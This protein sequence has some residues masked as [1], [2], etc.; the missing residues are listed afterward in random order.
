MSLANAAYTMAKLY[1]KLKLEFGPMNTSLARKTCHRLVLGATLLTTSHLHA[2]EPRPVTTASLDML[3]VSA[4]RDAPAEVV[5]LNRAMLSAELNARIVAVRAE[6]GDRVA[7]GDVL[8]ELD[9]RDYIAR[10]EQAAATLA[11]LEAQIDFA[12]YRSKRART[13]SERNAVAEEALRER[14]TTL[15]R[16]VAERDGQRAA[17]GTARLQVERCMVRAP[18]SAA[19][20]A[21]P[22]QLG[23]LAAPGTPLVELLDVES[24]EVRARVRRGLIDSLDNAAEVL[25]NDGRGDF[26][27]E[28]R[29]ILPDVDPRGDS[30]ELRLTFAA[31]RAA[32]GTPG[33]LVWRDAGLALPP[34]LVEERDGVSGVFTVNDDRA[35]FVPLVDVQEG[36]PVVVDLSPDTRLVIDGRAGLAD[37]D[38]VRDVD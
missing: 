10:A 11:A 38:P 36:R 14:E 27:L 13:L 25:F 16:L 3:A 8:V 5:S 17:L 34:Y 26:A 31:R 2:A 6:V 20:V 23:A 18:F 35:H 24:V 9:C 15:Q 12:D 22:A 7:V 30:V 4:S 29:A 37:G 33:R 21:R 1:N 19:I 28:R 32:P